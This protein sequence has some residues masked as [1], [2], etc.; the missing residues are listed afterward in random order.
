[1]GNVS[2]SSI[3]G[4]VFLVKPF[5]QR[6]MSCEPNNDTRGYEPLMI[7]EIDNTNSHTYMLFRHHLLIMN[8]KKDG[9]KAIRFDE[10]LLVEAL[11]EL[12]RKEMP[13]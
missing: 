11:H 4:C 9:S 5:P 12:R 3:L 7:Q 10:R 2:Q 6:I 8:K 13:Q 1:M